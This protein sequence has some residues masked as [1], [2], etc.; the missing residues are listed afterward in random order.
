MSDR[1]ALL[2]ALTVERYGANQWWTRRGPERR[3]EVTSDDEISTARRR[4]EMDA[5]FR[6]VERRKAQ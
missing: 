2:D 6:D 1:Q 4:R 3:H 5:D